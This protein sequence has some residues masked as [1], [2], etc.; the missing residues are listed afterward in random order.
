MSTS[1][2]A[3]RCRVTY[4]MIHWWAERGIIDCERRRGRSGGNG[5][6]R[7]WDERQ[8]LH[9]AI[10]A[11]L[12]RKGISIQ[13]IRPLVGEFRKQKD[14]YLVTD[15]YSVLWCAQ[16]AVIPTVAIASGGCHVVSLDDLRLQINGRR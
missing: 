15:G 2:L 10:V 7:E 9:V 4:R 16:D 12:R 3:R 14:E 8:A 13:Q 11:E 5:L 1:D 6:A